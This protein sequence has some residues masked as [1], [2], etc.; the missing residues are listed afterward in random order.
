MKSTKLTALTLVVVASFAAGAV[1][2]PV[3][4]ID[5]DFQGTTPTAAPNTTD[6]NAYVIVDDPGNGTDV[7][8]GTSSASFGGSFI[9]T[10]SENV[11][12]IVEDF[13]SSGL[14]LAGFRGS[15]PEEGITQGT[16][17]FRF[18]ARRGG[19]IVGLGDIRIGN[20]GDLANGLGTSEFAI[21]LLSSTN[22][23]LY[24]YDEN[25]SLVE[26][27]SIVDQDIHDFVIDFD[28][29]TDTY[30]VTLDGTLLGDAG[31]PSNTTFNFYEPQSGIDQ[32][33]FTSF[34][35]GGS[36]SKVF[37]DDLLVTA[38]PEPATLTLVL[39]GGLAYLRRR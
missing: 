20:N 11:S 3:V 7:Y 25:G 14:A 1:A 34:S 24:R 13:N 28:T 35:S 5:E 31:N 33:D 37:F 12:L 4:Y 18:A 36:N 6:P 8:I 38:V 27:A 26:I 21:W 22:G 30:T 2:T 19:G 39:V 10:P 17:S 16:V 23:K 32:V 15:L 9:N 29:D